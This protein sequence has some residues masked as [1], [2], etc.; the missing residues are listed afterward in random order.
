ME[1]S[2]A[3]IDSGRITFDYL[4]LEDYAAM[5]PK[6]HRDIVAAV[7]HGQ[8]ELPFRPWP[9]VRSGLQPLARVLCVEV[10]RAT[11]PLTY[12]HDDGFSLTC[13][14]DYLFASCSARETEGVTLRALVKNLYLRL[15]DLVRR[16]G[17]PHLL[18]VWNMVPSINTD[19]DGME[20][21]KLFCLGRHEGF[22]SKILDLTAAYPAA[23]GIGCHGDDLR[24]YFLAARSPGMTIENPRQV[25][26]Y[27]YPPRY[28]PKSP[29]FSRALVKTWGGG[30][31][32][33][34][35]GTASV[36][37]HES[38][39]QGDLPG[40]VEETLR[41][42]EI[43]TAAGAKA[44]GSAFTLA[45]PTSLLKA[46]IR[47]A[48]DYFETRELLE[49]HLGADSHVLYLLT[50]LCRRELLVELDGIVYA[51]PA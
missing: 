33:F 8:F 46:Y 36:V 45:S 2:R 34:L 49:R 40:Q 19:Q 31:G 44:S 28:G 18:R 9:Q 22:S 6:E 21:Y 29:L 5:D 20:R 51:D 10:I 43:L 17:Y 25:S 27:A 37:G 32:L 26:A 24:L 38:R 14:Q 23:C 15:I 12:G 16:R 41:N 7:A 11:G 4:S 50:D 35:S 42:L 48:S 39:H 47:R 30:A 1:E 3:A 13:T